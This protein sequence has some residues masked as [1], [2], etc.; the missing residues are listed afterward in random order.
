MHSDFLF[1]ISSL[2]YLFEQFSE[3]IKCYK[4]RTNTKS[5]YEQKPHIVLKSQDREITLSSESDQR[6]GIF[7][8]LYLI[9]R[10]HDQVK[11]NWNDPINQAFWIYDIPMLNVITN[12]I[13]ELSRSINQA[14]SQMK[15]SE[16]EIAI[17][18]WS[19]E[20]HNS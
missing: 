5:S 2:V 14:I 13:R 11:L 18:V 4:L 20:H 19:N 6:T 3:H 17:C 8:F 10:K 9:Y 15:V 7:G 16:K 12:L 1:L